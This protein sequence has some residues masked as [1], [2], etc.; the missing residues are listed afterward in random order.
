MFF[1][2]ITVKSLQSAG[3]SVADAMFVRFAELLLFDWCEK[4]RKACLTRRLSS[5]I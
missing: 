4:K 2:T 5:D 3:R 1:Q